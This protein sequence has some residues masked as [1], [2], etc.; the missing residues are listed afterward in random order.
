MF[1]Q[2]QGDLDPYKT[3]QYPTDDLYQNISSIYHQDKADRW[4]SNIGRNKAVTFLEDETDEVTCENEE[5]YEN[6]WIK[7]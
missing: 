1:P 5:I 6:L 4:H 3:L 7:M 2:D